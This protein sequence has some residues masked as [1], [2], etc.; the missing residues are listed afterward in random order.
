MFKANVQEHA[1]MPFLG[2]RKKLAN[3]V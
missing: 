2:T 3:A 1:T